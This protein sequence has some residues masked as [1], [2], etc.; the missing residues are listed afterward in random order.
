M[1]GHRVTSMANVNDDRQHDRTPNGPGA[2]GRG[3]AD[4]TAERR[5]AKPHILDSGAFPFNRMNRRHAALRV[6]TRRSGRRIPC[7]TESAYR[8]TAKSAAVPSVDVGSNPLVSRNPRVRRPR[9]TS[10]WRR[11]AR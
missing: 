8:A 7:N 3:G 10:R 11:T 9:T 1:G 4:G 6:T 5:A 2:S